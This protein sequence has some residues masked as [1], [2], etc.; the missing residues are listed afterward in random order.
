MGCCV[1]SAGKCLH[2]PRCEALQART[3]RVCVEGEFAQT[4]NADTV[5]HFSQKLLTRTLGNGVYLQYEN[6]QNQVQDWGI[7]PNDAGNCQNIKALR[8]EGS[9]FAFRS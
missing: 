6:T 9:T 4:L 3:A 5:R 1:D 2:L 8:A 7:L